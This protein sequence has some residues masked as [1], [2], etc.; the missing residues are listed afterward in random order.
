MSIYNL[1]NGTIIKYKNKIKVKFKTP[2]REKRVIFKIC[3]INLMEYFKFN[4][5]FKTFLQSNLN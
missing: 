2:T 3:K 5:T 4:Y 1:L